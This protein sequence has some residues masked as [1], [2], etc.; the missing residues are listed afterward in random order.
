MTET[1]PFASCREALDYLYHFTDY[2]RMAKPR[3]AA[4]SIFGLGRMTKLLAA[5]GHPER[6]LRVV[7]IAGTKGK[8]STAVMTAAILERSGARVGLYTSPHVESV[9]E[10]IMVDRQWIPEERLVAHVNRMHAYLQESLGS[11]ATYTPTFFEIFTAAAFLDFVAERVDYAVFEVGL[12]GRLDAT[13]VTL[14]VVCGITPVSFDHTD[15]LGDTLDRIGW[16]KAG[17]LKPRVPVVVGPQEPEALEGIRIRTRPLETPVRMVGRD[18]VL[19][20]D[21][22]VTARRRYDGVRAPLAGAHQ[23]T[24]AAMAVAL[25]E[26]AMC[27]WGLRLEPRIVREGLASVSW[28]ARIEQVAENPAVI[29]DAAHNRASIRALLDTLAERHP[30]PRTV[31]VVGVSSDKDVDGILGELIPR[32]AGLVFSRSESPRACPPAVLLER[33]RALGATDAVARDDPV[34]AVALARE[35]ATEDGL[36]CVTGSFYLA[37]EVITALLPTAT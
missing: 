23:R 25:A 24:N 35:R 8:G 13:N 17:I 19:D 14:P 12:G 33:A 16:E 29:V 21:A 9:L 7:H 3:D 27:S 15:K 10:R 20:G 30:N 36:V 11:S 1:G 22:V 2:E 18:I 4:T 32:A 34:Q 5:L 26:E 37:G 6:R 31:F 28:R